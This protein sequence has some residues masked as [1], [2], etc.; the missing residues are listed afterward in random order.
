M[1][2]I[3]KLKENGST[4]YPATI[5]EAVVDPET[6]EKWSSSGLRHVRA[7][8]YG[9]YYKFLSI[10][11]NA[12]K[13]IVRFSISSPLMGFA[14]YMLKWRYETEAVKSCKAVCI[15]A[16]GAEMHE[17]VKLVRTGNASFDVYFESNTGN[18][19]PSCVFL[20]EGGTKTTNAVKGV[21]VLVV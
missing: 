2:R 7:T 16:T 5:S 6:G 4:I 3:K 9:R 20:G 15:S 17:R 12:E 14:D 8:A 13:G 10:A 1:A 21:S 18:D 11:R 19:Y